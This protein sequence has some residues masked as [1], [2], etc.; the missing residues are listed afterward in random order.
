[1]SDYFYIGIL[2]FMWLQGLC[3]GYV[4]W[5]SETRFKRGFLDGLTFKWLW[6]RK[7]RE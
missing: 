1:M 5:A 3:L 7:N 2:V 6:K 4:L